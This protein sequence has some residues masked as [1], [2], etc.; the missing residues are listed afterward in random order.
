V[1]SYLN[2]RLFGGVSALGYTAVSGSDVGLGFHTDPWGRS[3]TPLVALSNMAVAVRRL[4]IYL[5]EW[6]IPALVPLAVWAIFCR[7]RAPSDLVLAVGAIA[8]PVLYFFYWHSGFYPGP[9]FYYIGAPFFVVATARAWCWAWA[10]VRDNKKWGVRWDI[11][12]GSA[13]AVV[14]LWGW[15]SLVPGRWVFYRD[16]LV[17]LKRHP[18]RQLAARGVQQALVMVPESWGSR[19]VTNLWG[20]G[21]PQA[22]VER[23]FHRADACDLHQLEQQLRRNRLGVEA[24]V[25][26]LENM[27]ARTGPSVAPIANWPDPSLRLRPRETIPEECRIEMNRDLQ[28]F[29]LFGH[30]AWRNAVGLESGVVFARDLHDRNGELLARYEGWEV[31]R[32]APLPDDPNSVPVLTRLRSAQGSPQ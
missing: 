17:S 14:L 9:R 18:E 24:V 1:W 31:W 7:R 23:A 10:G 28:G 8:G 27:L 19:I 13:A 2:W 22:L 15:L 4:N 21:A 11:A 12:L 16:Q 30:L 20:L 29:T 25:D 26:S 6:P 5:F 32:Y 3:Y